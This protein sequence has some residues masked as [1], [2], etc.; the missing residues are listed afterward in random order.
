ME[1]IKAFHVKNIIYQKNELK[2]FILSFWKIFL[3]H[4]L[5]NFWT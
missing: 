5:K 4:Y 1:K 3:L 2:N